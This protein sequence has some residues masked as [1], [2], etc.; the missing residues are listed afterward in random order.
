MTK[1]KQII[2]CQKQNKKH[3]YFLCSLYCGNLNHL[4][5]MLTSQRHNNGNEIVDGIMKA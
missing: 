1:A 5:T 4:L 2:N 3:T